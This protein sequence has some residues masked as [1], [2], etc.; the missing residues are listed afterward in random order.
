MLNKK[1]ASIE[2]FLSYLK[3]TGA[4]GAPV[5]R[6]ELILLYDKDVAAQITNEVR[7]NAANEHILDVAQAALA[8]NDQIG[9]ER[10]D[11]L[12]V[13]SLGNATGFHDDANRGDVGVVA[14]GF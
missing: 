14:G 10:L 7:G 9:I 6:A 4:A 11:E 12:L 3:E 5:V 8:A 2:K 13:Q 1:K